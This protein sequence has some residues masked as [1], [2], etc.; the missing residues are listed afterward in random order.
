MVMDRGVVFVIVTY[1]PHEKTMEKLVETLGEKDVIV[2]NNT[3]DNRGYAGGA[4]AG[5]RKALER[6]AHWIV[7]MNDDLEITKEFVQQFTDSLKKS[8][9]AIAGP[10]AGTLDP[11]RWT[12]TV[13]ATTVEYIS[14]SCFAIH[15]DVIG[16]IGY[17]Y[18]PYFIYYEEVDYCIRAKRSGF[19][20]RW[21]PIA[22][23]THKESVTMET[24]SFLQQYYLARNHLLFVQRQAPLHVKL[25]ELFRLPKT[26]AEHLMRREWGALLGVFHYVIRHFGRLTYFRLGVV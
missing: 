2:V 13:P 17:L 14:G 18:E 7:V 22:G 4:N 20:L 3:T 25:Y 8:P 11:K 1:K 26:L 6:G 5:I 12:A 9:A 16:K 10:C 15:R 19:P 23:I 24:G 21:L